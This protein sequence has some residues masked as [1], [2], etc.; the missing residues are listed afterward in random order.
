M[1]DEKKTCLNC[2]FLVWYL[3]INEGHVDEVIRT[4]RLKLENTSCYEIKKL[5]ECPI[6]CA[7]FIWESQ[8]FKILKNSSPGAHLNLDDKIETF[9]EIM[10]QDRS[11]C[12]FWQK[13]EPGAT[14]ETGK[15]LLQDEIKREQNEKEQEFQMNRAKEERDEQKKQTQKNRN[16]KVAT[17]GVFTVATLGNFVFYFWKEGIP[18]SFWIM[19]GALI[20]FVL[21]LILKK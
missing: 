2:H 1:E 8:D 20:I 11:V 3:G 19:A 13:Y 16:L 18:F 14:I 6:G 10:N 17:L 4:D 15:R 12:E 21:H 5:Q 9:Q 7:Y